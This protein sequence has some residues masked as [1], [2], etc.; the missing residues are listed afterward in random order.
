MRRDAHIDP[1]LF[2]LFLRS[3]VYLDYARRFLEPEQIDEVDIGAVLKA[4]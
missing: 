2:E 3:G 1:A 4:A